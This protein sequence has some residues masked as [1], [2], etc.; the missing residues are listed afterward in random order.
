[1]PCRFMYLNTWCQ[2]NSTVWEGYGIFKRWSCWSKNN[3]G[4]LWGLQPGLTYLWFPLTTY[5][6]GTDE[7]GSLCF[8]TAMPYAFPAMLDQIP[9]RTVSQNK[10][11]SPNLYFIRVFYHSKKSNKCKMQWVKKKFPYNVDHTKK[12]KNWEK[13]KHLKEERDK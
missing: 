13:Q 11:F 6:Q 3:E 4:R 2:V 5:F 8:L 7:M 12:K 1:M 10:F 9:W